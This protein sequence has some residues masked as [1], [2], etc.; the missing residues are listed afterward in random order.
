[1]GLSD[2]E[3]RVEPALAFVQHAQGKKFLRISVGT[4]ESD[5]ILNHLIDRIS[6]DLLQRLRP[7]QRTRQVF[8]F[9]P[10]ISE[11]LAKELRVAEQKLGRHGST[12]AAA[13]HGT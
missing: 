5:S 9:Q 6:P 2:H 11:V 4:Q 3:M 10:A 1:M 7:R 12:I 13:I 8:L